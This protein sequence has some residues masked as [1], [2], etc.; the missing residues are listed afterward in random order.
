MKYYLGSIIATAAKRQGRTPLVPLLA[1][2]KYPARKHLIFRE[3]CDHKQG[4]TPEDICWRKNTPSIC[5]R[6]YQKSVADSRVGQGPKQLEAKKYAKEWAQCYPDWSISDICRQYGFSPRLVAN[7]L[8]EHRI[9][10]LSSKEINR[11]KYRKTLPP[12][13]G[14]LHAVPP[15]RWDTRGRRLYECHGPSHYRPVRVWLKPGQHMACNRN[16]ARQRNTLSEVN[17]FLHDS[18]CTKVRWKWH[19]LYFRDSVVSYLCPHK[20]RVKKR[21]RSLVAAVIYGETVCPHVDNFWSERVVRLFVRKAVLPTYV[22]AVG[23][24]SIK[25]RGGNFTFDIAVLKDGIPVAYIE[26]GSHQIAVRYGGMSQR[27]ADKS[28]LKIQLNDRRKKRW[29]AKRGTPLLQ[30]ET[31]KRNL[32]WI[33][34]RVWNWL[35]QWH[36]AR[37]TR[38]K[39]SYG[40]AVQEVP[41]ASELRNAGLRPGDE[42]W[43]AVCST[44][45]WQFRYEL[46]VKRDLAD[47]HC[48]KCRGGVGKHGRTRK[49]IEEQA[50][51]LGVKFKLPSG[52]SFNEDVHGQSEC[53]RCGEDISPTVADLFRSNW[54]R[55]CK[56][57]AMSRKTA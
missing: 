42:R 21:W 35:Q 50:N 28:L 1:N 54:S 25:V 43:K 13:E 44:C 57:C 47:L 4:R 15:G 6:C 38:P 11:R 40:D 55:R 9:K 7:I 53:V 27:A 3:S 51:A 48:P 31:G 45:D 32:D 29:A 10:I 12:V 22:V 41:Y 52:Q 49:T 30:L 20:D 34:N 39:V 5:I 36:L 24:T 16:C 56:P 19:S 37:R 17:K 23:P 26:P 46:Q 33:L 2:K 8:R 18:G 14:H